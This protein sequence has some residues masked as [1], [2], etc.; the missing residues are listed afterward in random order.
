[1]EFVYTTFD[2]T[3]GPKTGPNL[4]FCMSLVNSQECSFVTSECSR[5]IFNH[6]IE[7]KRQLDFE[8]EHKGLEKDI[9]VRRIELRTDISHLI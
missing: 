7:L 1:M 5:F 9:Y 8:K 4:S 2:H 3:D 6:F